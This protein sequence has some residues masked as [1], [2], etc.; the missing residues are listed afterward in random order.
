MVGMRDGRQGWMNGMG[1]CSQNRQ[2]KV[3]NKCKRR[4]KRVG[5]TETDSDRVTVMITENY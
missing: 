2:R 5:E 4:V 1:R 3:D